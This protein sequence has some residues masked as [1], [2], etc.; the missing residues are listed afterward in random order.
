[1]TVS[2]VT[3]DKQIQKPLDFYKVIST[4]YKQESCIILWESL[5]ADLFCQSDDKMFDNTGILYTSNTNVHIK[6]LRQLTNE[7]NYKW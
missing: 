1:M 4:S 2:I 3:W 7:S 5:K 6:I